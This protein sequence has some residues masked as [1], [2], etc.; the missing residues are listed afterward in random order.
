MRYT[1]NEHH[2]CH[3]VQCCYTHV[4]DVHSPVD[5]S[6]LILYNIFA[7]STKMEISARVL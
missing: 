2:K 3:V 5:D 1:L 6:V 4:Q 7:S